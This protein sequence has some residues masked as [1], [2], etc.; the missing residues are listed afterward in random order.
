MKLHTIWIKRYHSLG[1]ADCRCTEQIV[2]PRD[3][4]LQRTGREG[5]RL[6][7]PLASLHLWSLPLAGAEYHYTKPQGGDFFNGLGWTTYN[8]QTIFSVLQPPSSSPA[9]L[10]SKPGGINP[11]A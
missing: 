9:F 6:L 5:F 10:I 4:L 8:R 2:I 11:V 1:V 7:A 3:E